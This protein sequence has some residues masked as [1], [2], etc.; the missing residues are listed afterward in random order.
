MGEISAQ[1]KSWKHNV[2]VF[3]GRGQMVEIPYA[4]CA[5]CCC[6]LKWR[7]GFFDRLTAHSL[8]YTGTYQQGTGIGERFPP[9]TTD[10]K[11]FRKLHFDDMHTR[12]ERGALATY[13]QPFSGCFFGWF[14][15]VC[16]WGSVCMVS[17]YVC[18]AASTDVFPP[19]CAVTHRFDGLNLI[20]K[21]QFS[22]T[23]SIAS[24]IRVFALQPWSNAP[25][26]PKSRSHPYGRENDKSRSFAT[27]DGFVGCAGHNSECAPT[28]PGVL[29]QVLQCWWWKEG[30]QER[31]GS[32]LLMQ[33]PSVGSTISLSREIVSL[34]CLS[35][36]SAPNNG[37]NKGV[38][39][40]PVSE[41]FTP[42]GLAVV[43]RMNGVTGGE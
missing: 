12:L 27:I 19:N 2:L 24:P 17:Q 36:L 31:K 34:H 38:R 6:Q 10:A 32:T 16:V 18:V 37:L 43:R 8:T 21:T 9:K 22:I 14:F 33:D 42:I 30:V 20:C 29:Q 15:D 11:T 7:D 25:I 5:F 13:R 23:V 35:S 3:W 40:A 39:F 4:R 26:P 28:V 41:D 1:A